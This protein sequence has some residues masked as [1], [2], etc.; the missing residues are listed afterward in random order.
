MFGNK[1]KME[2]LKK[3]LEQEKQQLLLIKEQ[4]E[5]TSPKIDIYDVYIWENKGIYN[6][7][8]LYIQNIRGNTWRGFGPVKNGYES[9]L[10]DIFSN[11]TVYQKS[12]TMKIEKEEYV[13][14]ETLAE[15]YYAHLIPICE[16]EPNLLAYADKKVPLYVLQQLYYNLNKVDV[17]ASILKKEYK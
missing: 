15:G 4:L 11:H 3:E 12:S 6:I 1:K 7:V 5:D 10:V 16:I 9:T 17:N 13:A 8:K 2:Q 14:G